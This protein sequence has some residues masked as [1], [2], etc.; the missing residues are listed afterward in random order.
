MLET[1]PPK[2]HITGKLNNN[3]NNNNNSNNDKKDKQA[4]SYH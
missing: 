1:L 2:I 4:Y 3:N